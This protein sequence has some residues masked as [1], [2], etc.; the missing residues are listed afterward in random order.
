M[1]LSTRK[2]FIS[3][4]MGSVF[5]FSSSVSAGEYFN[6]IASFP[7]NLNLPSDMSQ[8]TETSAEIISATEDGNMVVYSDSPL[9]A[10][11]MIDIT[12]SAKPAPLGIIKLGGEPTSVSI[13]S[14]FAFVGV[15]TSKDYVS[16]SGNLT[17]VDLKSKSI[18]QSCDLGGQP[19]SVAISKDGSLVAV[20]I[21]NERD[22]DL[23]DG[24]IPQMPAGFV[25]IVPMRDGK[26]NCDAM[27]KADITGLADIA[28]SDPETEFVDFN[29]N[30]ELVITLQENNYIVIMSADGKV[31]SHFSAGS[32][33]LK[34]VDVDEERALTFDGVLNDVPR[35]PD[36]VQW[37]DNDRFVTANEGDYKGGSRGFTIFSRSGE[38]LHDSGLD[39]EY[40]V[41]MAGHYPEKRSGNKGAEPEGLE[42]GKFGGSTYM[43]VMSE[44]GSVIGVYKDTGNEP[45]FVQL[46]PTGLAPEGAVAIPGRNLLVVS[47]EKDLIEDGGV[48]SHVTLYKYGAEASRYPM[49]TSK[50]DDNGRPIG[51]G[52]LS[53]LVGD[54]E[55]PGMFYA[56]NDS[57]Y[58]SQPQIFKIDASQQPAQIISALPITRDGMPAQKLD[59][60][61]ITLDG[62]GGYFIASEGRNGRLTPH[63]IY[64]VNA[65]G[66]IEDE[67]A[68]PE[69]LLAVQKRFGSEGIAKHGD[70]LWIAIQREWQDDQDGFVK[71]VNYNLKSKEWGAVSYPLDGKDMGWVGLSEISIF[72][73]NAYI[74]ERDNQIGAAAVTKKIY[75]VALSELKPAK[76]GSE[77]PVVKKQLHKD[78]LPIMQSYGGYVLDKV[79]GLG[80][81][82][83]GEM[84]I[85]TDNDGVDDSNGETQF[86][87]LDS[88]ASM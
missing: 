23:N 7:V 38:I 53:G 50:L 21:E 24:I 26:L 45:E 22:E 76:L 88:M 80:I 16:P 84:V 27:I 86:I 6:R 15:N 1:R 48:R 47:N 54:A 10:I 33:D 57:F 4:L 61:G 17:V 79:E 52:A 31:Q 44:R 68:F 59:M 62:E 5:T 40:R 73:D 9:G 19:D 77:L 32:V 71:L 39:F 64:H 49:L 67:I 35:E 18:T 70:D 29:D 12:D 20:A 78:L 66:E 8:K 11:G 83:N 36:A 75:K 42:V 13:K 34:N 69:E 58:R 14:G 82:K 56:V 25:S 74:L 87:K 55:T 51:W 28:G 72:G 37:L 43:F 63:A 3:F 30:N 46:L 85:V 60:E 41:A 81:D 65:K 2:I